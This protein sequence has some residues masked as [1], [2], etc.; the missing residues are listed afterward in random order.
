MNVESGLRVWR[1]NV[2][3]VDNSAK[4]EYRGGKIEKSGDLR[5]GGGF[6]G[7]TGE[8]VVPDGVE[9]GAQSK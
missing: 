3:S 5:D 2:G 8:E 9:N 6:G 1:G 7:G 4:Q